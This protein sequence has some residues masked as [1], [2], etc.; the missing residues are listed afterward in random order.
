[1]AAQQ[2]S[3]YLL[4]LLFKLNLNMEQELC[5]TVWHWIH[6]I[7]LGSTLLMLSLHQHQSSNKTQTKPTPKATSTSLATVWRF[8]PGWLKV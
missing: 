1:M 2:Q 6:K 8:E 3:F 7:M 5:E 4:I